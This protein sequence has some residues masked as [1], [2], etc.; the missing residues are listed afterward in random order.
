M[1]GLF[2]KVKSIYEFFLLTV[3]TA[4]AVP[5]ASNEINTI[6]ASLSPVLGTD[7]LLVFSFGGFFGGVFSSGGTG[8]FSSSGTGGLYVFVT[9]ISNAG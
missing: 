7:G 9:V 8:G 2:E 3:I 6:N 5:M 1:Q 4:P